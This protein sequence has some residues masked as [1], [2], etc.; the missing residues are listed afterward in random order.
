MFY[1]HKIEFKDGTILILK[2][3]KDKSIDVI[4]VNASIGVEPIASNHIT[5]RKINTRVPYSTL[6][7][8]KKS[9]ILEG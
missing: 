6:E 7:K 4:M 1:S 3:N 9:G 5:I 8:L 2:E